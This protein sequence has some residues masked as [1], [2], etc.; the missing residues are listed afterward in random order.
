MSA[1]RSLLALVALALAPWA[2]AQGT[3]EEIAK[4]RAALQEGNPAELWEIRGADLWRQKRGPKQ[5][6]L[7]G[8][9][10]GLGTGIVKG[11]YA[12]MPRY[13][14]DAD[15]VMDLET[16]QPEESLKVK[17][18]LESVPGTIRTRILY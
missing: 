1:T 2:L 7:E 3:S 5:V 4:Y 6:S 16:R 11:A 8:C 10:L 17:H 15:R 12:Q 18:R 13:F 9:D 14:A